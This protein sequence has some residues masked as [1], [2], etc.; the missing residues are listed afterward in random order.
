MVASFAVKHSCFSFYNLKKTDDISSFLI[1]II[2]E[3]LFLQKGRKNSLPQKTIGLKTEQI[4]NTFFNED[5]QIKGV[6]EQ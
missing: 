1:R 4:F 3:Y 5:I 2:S 6:A